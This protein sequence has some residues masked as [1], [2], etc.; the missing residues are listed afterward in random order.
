MIKNNSTEHCFFLLTAQKGG[1]LRSAFEHRTFPAA[2]RG[3]IPEGVTDEQQT[4]LCLLYIRVLPRPS[5][6]KCDLC[7]ILLL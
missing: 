4:E 7:I 1:A 5:T 3:G 6:F 2:E